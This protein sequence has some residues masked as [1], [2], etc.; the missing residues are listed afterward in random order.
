MAESV[1]DGCMSVQLLGSGWAAVHMVLVKDD[2]L[3]EY[4]DVQQTGIGRYATRDEAVKEAVNWC[5]TNEIKPDK[6]LEFE[7]ATFKSKQK[8]HKN[9]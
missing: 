4:W 9:G 1:I 5:F 8:E 3:G 2:E 7:Y 6:A